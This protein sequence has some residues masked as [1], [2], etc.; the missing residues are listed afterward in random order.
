MPDTGVHRTR[1][2]SADAPPMQADR[3]SR[4]LLQ[5]ASVRRLLADRPELRRLGA[6]RQPGGGRSEVR[7]R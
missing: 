2:A 4:L 6:G 1:L 7:V 5:L 3:S